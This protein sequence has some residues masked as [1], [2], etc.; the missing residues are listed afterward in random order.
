MK[1]KSMLLILSIFITIIF[2]LVSCSD[3]NGISPSGNEIFE[4]TIP[5]EEKT[6]IEFDKIIL[7][8]DEGTFEEDLEIQIEIT[9]SLPSNFANYESLGELYDISHEV[10]MTLSPKTGPTLMCENV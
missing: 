5:S 7:C 3:D 1:I 4:Q 8:F 6:T 2:T 10:V 9:D